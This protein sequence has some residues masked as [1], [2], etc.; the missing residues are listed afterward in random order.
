[1]I[2]TGIHLA[3]ECKLATKRPLGQHTADGHLERISRVPVDQ[4]GKGGLLE[5]TCITGMMI[6]QLVFA[7][8]T[9]DFYLSCIDYDHIVADFLMGSVTR[10]V[11]AAEDAG[12]PGGHT[13][14]TLTLGINDEPVAGYFSGFNE[15]GL[16]GA[17]PSPCIEFLT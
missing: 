9:T 2:G 11:L 5:A 6:V 1:M 16:Q 3:V 13:A 7:L 4:L 10:L 14:E 17:I 8:A 15:Y 12:N